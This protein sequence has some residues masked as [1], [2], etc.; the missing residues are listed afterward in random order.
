MFLNVCKGLVGRKPEKCGREVNV[1]LMMLI[2]VK[3]NPSC[4]RTP[5]QSFLLQRMVSSQSKESVWPGLRCLKLVLKK[6]LFALVVMVLEEVFVPKAV[7][8]SYLIPQ[9]LSQNVH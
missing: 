5:N 2:L 8:R 6:C 9:M 3:V 7:C 1:L 4:K